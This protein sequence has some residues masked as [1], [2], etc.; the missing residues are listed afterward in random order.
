MIYRTASELG[1]TMILQNKFF[2]HLNED[3]LCFPSS[4]LQILTFSTQLIL[5]LVESA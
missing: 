3:I 2:I 4:Q 5:V 1:E